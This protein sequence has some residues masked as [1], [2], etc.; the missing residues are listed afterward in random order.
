M[1]DRHAR[2]AAAATRHSVL[3]PLPLDGAYDYE[4]SLEMALEPGEFV[5]V[6]L[7]AR[8]VAGVVWGAAKSDI[9]AKK[10]RRVIQ[11][12]DAPPL[13][14]E[15]RRLVDWVSAYT[16]S[17]PGAVLRMAMSVPAALE[18][19]RGI[20]AFALAPQGRV[21]LA[22]GGDSLSPARRRV[23]ECLSAGP[24]LPAAELAR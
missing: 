6:P 15:L 18:P 23:L 16:L 7:G 3:L 2:C 12:L 11:R 5:A 22:S 14:G 20:A 24:P 1:P 10:L 21:A 17:P 8:T 13:K 19:M 9:A 4:A